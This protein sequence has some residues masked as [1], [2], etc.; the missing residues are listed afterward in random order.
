MDA[1]FHPQKDALAASPFF[2]R[3]GLPNSRSA[4]RRRDL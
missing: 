2:S 1:H 4:V 3:Y